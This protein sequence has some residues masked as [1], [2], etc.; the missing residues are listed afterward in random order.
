[1]SHLSLVLPPERNSLDDWPCA[2]FTVDALGRVILANVGLLD[3]VGLAKADVLG[4]AAALLWAPEARLTWHGQVLPDLDA[5]GQV[6]DVPMLLQ[7]RSGRVT[8]VSMS[9]RAHTLPDGGTV[10]RVVCVRQ[11]ARRDGEAQ[12]RMLQRVAQDAPGM[13]FQMRM[14]PD[15]QVEFTCIN[16]AV[17]CLFDLAPEQVLQHP[18]R[19][20]AAMDPA[21]LAVLRMGLRGSASNFQPWSQQYRAWVRG[22]WRWHEIHASPAREADGSLLWHGHTL[23]ITA[24]KS[25]A[26]SLRDKDAAEQANRTKSAFLTRMSH[27]LRTPLHGILGFARL[28]AAPDGGLSEVNRQ[29]AGHIES[30]GDSLL[31]LINDVL[32]ISR[33]EVGQLAISLGPVLLDGVCQEALALIEPQAQRRHVRLHLHSPGGVWVQADAQRAQQVLMNLLSNAVK[34]GPVGGEVCVQVSGAASSVTVSVSDQGPGL[35]PAQQNGLFQAFNPL[36][37]EASGVDGVGLGLVISKSLVEQMGG[38]LRLEPHGGPGST[39]SLIL[40]R[41]QPDLDDAAQPSAPAASFDSEVA[42]PE[43]SPQPALRVLY[44]EDNRV[45]AVLMEAV[46]DMQSRFVLQV[47][48]DGRSALAQ[49]LAEPPDALLLDM[50]LPDTD[51]ITLLAQLRQLP[52]LA[53]VPAAAVSA[54]AMPADIERALESG[55]AVYW[56]KPLD[57]SRLLDAV[58]ALLEGRAATSRHGAPPSGGTISA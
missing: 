44:V 31:R 7:H 10:L 40:P 24:R 39:F 37:A 33:I 3:W 43:A 27:E 15:G 2:A 34:Y 25:M 5:S 46:F 17:V 23:D 9:A 18:D 41:A 52:G 30:G 8:E 22:E 12:L 36:G 45:N 4:Q 55:F 49:A 14:Q 6:E 13:L 21:D 57:V 32:D 19:L 16:K 56:T 26:H 53:D 1:M 28:L 51:G 47:A 11:Q 38:H 35:S 20:W 29:R 58:A 54:D 48:S 50:H 42:A